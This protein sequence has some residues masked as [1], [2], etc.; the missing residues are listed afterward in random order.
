MWTVPVAAGLSTLVLLACA[1]ALVLLLVF[2]IRLLR[3][4]DVLDGAL[5]RVEKAQRD[6]ALD[7]RARLDEAARSLVGIEERVQSET[8]SLAPRIETVSGRVAELERRLEAIAPGVLSATTQSGR[9][10]EQ[11]RTAAE[12]AAAAERMAAEARSA[13]PALSSRLDQLDRRVREAESRLADLARPPAAGLPPARPPALPPARPPARPPVVAP[14]VAP[15]VAAGGAAASSR[16]SPGAVA[17]PPPPVRPEP[18]P[19]Q[20]PEPL[21]REVGEYR[22]QGESAGGEAP[23]MRAVM[24]LVIVLAVVSALFHWISVNQ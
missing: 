10:E 17:P 13:P 3:R 23:G 19:Q 24:A 8:G 14:V 5:V 12:R 18:E 11:A 4:V 15:A 6:G 22:F 16:P 7:A 21:T 9:A 1:V 20:E 2:Q